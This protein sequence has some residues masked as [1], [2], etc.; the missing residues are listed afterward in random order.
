MSLPPL[1]DLVE[2][3]GAL[4]AAGLKPDKESRRKLEKLLTTK[5]TIR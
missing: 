4:M 5:R 1:K 3:L 2:A